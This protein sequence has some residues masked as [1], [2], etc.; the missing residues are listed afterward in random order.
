MSFTVSEEGISRHA[1]QGFGHRDHGAGSKDQGDSAA[2]RVAAVGDLAGQEMVGF[3]QGCFRRGSK[4][5]VEVSLFGR[6]DLIRRIRSKMDLAGV[7]SAKPIA[8][9]DFF[10]RKNLFS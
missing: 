2:D 3:K 7:R 9:M 1:L 6:L 4:A 8:S 10:E 5:Q